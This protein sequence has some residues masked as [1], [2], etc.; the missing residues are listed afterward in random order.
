LEPEAAMNDDEK[1]LIEE[2]EKIYRSQPTRYGYYCGHPI[3]VC[4]EL[5]SVVKR[6]YEL[7]P[8]VKII[9]HVIGK[10]EL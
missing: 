4:K 2:M 3:S 9:R 5:L 1:K 7:V 8:H 6:Y 10:D